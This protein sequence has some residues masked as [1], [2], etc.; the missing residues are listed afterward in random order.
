MGFDSAHQSKTLLDFLE[1]S[2]VDHDAGSTEAQDVRMQ[3]ARQLGMAAIENCD[4][5][6][7]FGDDDSP[8]NSSEAPVEKKPRRVPRNSGEASMGNIEGM[9]LCCA[10][11]YH[12]NISCLVGTLS[13]L[14]DSANT[15]NQNRMQLSEAKLQFE[16]AR[17][18]FE[19]ATTEAKLKSEKETMR[20]QCAM[21]SY[22]TQLD[23]YKDEMSQRSIILYKIG[24]EKA[25][26][27]LGPPPSRP[28]PP[29]YDNVA[30]SL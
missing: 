5:D 22:R 21:E 24:V 26:T 15:A 9:P 14:V 3:A 28:K 13:A 2:N 8:D 20:F 17:F 29:S 11:D 7:I 1:C 16:E 4:G 6:L 19:K 18:Q 27:F 12:E 25:L 23:A 10:S 30:S